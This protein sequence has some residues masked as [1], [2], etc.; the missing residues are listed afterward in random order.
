VSKEVYYLAAYRSA[1]RN[2]KNTI[3]RRVNHQCAVCRSSWWKATVVIS[4]GRVVGHG[5]P[6]ICNECG[7]KDW[8]DA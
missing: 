8:L 6:V 4:E 7:E 1:R 5:L 3:A 2:G